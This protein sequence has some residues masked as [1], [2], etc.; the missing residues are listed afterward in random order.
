MSPPFQPRLSCDEFIDWYELRYGRWNHKSFERTTGFDATVFHRWR[1]KGGIPVYA[2]DKVA[3]A[4]GVHP[5]RI[6]R[7]WFR[8]EVPA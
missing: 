1:K 2:A 5:S 7:D 8:L 4:Y 3:I 6:W